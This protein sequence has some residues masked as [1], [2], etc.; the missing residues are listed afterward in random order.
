MD[1]TKN[2]MELINFDYRSFE[3][4][5]IA[6]RSLTEKMNSGKINDTPTG[7]IVGCEEIPLD[8]WE[9]ELSLND[10][11][12]II[13]SKDL[14]HRDIISYDSKKNT[15]ECASRNKDLKPINEILNI[16]NA[17]IY[18]VVERCM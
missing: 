8:E 18:K 2:T 5:Q 11:G 7:A 6:F 12:Y 3:G 16:E 1:K 14:L 13:K 4:T 9:K 17:Q 10:Y 15:I